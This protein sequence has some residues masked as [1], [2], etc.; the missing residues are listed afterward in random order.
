M[1]RDRISPP[2][3]TTRPRRWFSRW[4]GARKHDTAP[5]QV[6]LRLTTVELTVAADPGL[7]SPGMRVALVEDTCWAF[8]H[9]SWTAQRPPWW[10]RR[11]HAAWQAELQRLEAK[12]ERIRTLI[13]AEH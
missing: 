9:E 4:F 13:Q 8:A 1:E 7:L 5:R 12:R 2:S 10:H 11:E 6:G 3:A